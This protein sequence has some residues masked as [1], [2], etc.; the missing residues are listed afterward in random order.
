MKEFKPNKQQ[1]N[2]PKKLKPSKF[3]DNFIQLKGP[4]GV[5]RASSAEIQKN[6]KYF[7]LDLIYGN[8]VQEKY[9][10]FIM[11]DNRV[12]TEAITEAQNKLMEYTII[13]QSMDCAAM[14]SSPISLQ[15]VFPL[16]YN[17]YMY[18]ANA[19]H[20]MLNGLQGFAMTHDV[21]YLT[22]ISAKLNSSSI[23][24]GKQQIM[25]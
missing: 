21:S 12:I 14:S 24:G 13:T 25:I 4:N 8:I 9:L 16:I 22:A 10:P 2:T 20:I 19:Y 17:N 23:R 3:F 6:L 5:L 7:F 18:K 1:N 15:P 11:N